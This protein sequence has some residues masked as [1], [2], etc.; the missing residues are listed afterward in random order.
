MD[1]P[2]ALPEG[3]Y[4]TH[5]QAPPTNNHLSLSKYRYKGVFNG[6]KFDNVAIKLVAFFAKGS[7]SHRLLL[8]RGLHH[9]DPLWQQEPGVFASTNFVLPRRI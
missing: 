4:T 9:A 7:A 5:R 2:H 3:Q 8:I 1:I 6:K